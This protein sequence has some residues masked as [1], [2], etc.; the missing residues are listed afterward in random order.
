LPF[1]QI[2]AVQKGGKAQARVDKS[3][4]TLYIVPNHKMPQLADV[5]VRQAINHAINRQ[6]LIKAV[7]FGHGVAASSV[8][9]KGALWWNTSLTAPKYDLKLAQQYMKK[10]KYAKGFTLTMEVPAGDSVSNQIDVIMKDELKAIGITLDL[11][12]ADSTT[13][14]HNQQV[15]KYHMTNNLWTNDIPDPDELISFAVDYTLGSHSFYTWYKN[16][17]L[18][19]LSKA[20]E[21]TNNNAKRRANYLKIQKVFMDQVPFFPLFYVPFVNAISN[22]VHGFSENALGYFNLQ[23]VTKS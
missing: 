9:P 21:E 3:T 23:G 5:N 22:N 11:K 6:A 18:A 13:L 10:S 14:F 15:A 2:D 7:L 1:N 17:S 20:A 19:K 16:P 4:E 12:Q 8:M